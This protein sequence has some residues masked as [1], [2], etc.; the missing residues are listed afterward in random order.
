MENMHIDVRVSVF[1]LNL[2]RYSFFSLKTGGK[3][4]LF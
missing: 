3:N 2:F 1:F 4:C